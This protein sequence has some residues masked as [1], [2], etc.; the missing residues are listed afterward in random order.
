[1]V[2]LCSRFDKLGRLC[3]QF[4]GVIISWLSYHGF[5][6]PVPSIPQ[7]IPAIFNRIPLQLRSGI[8]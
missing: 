6:K 1:M 3:E 4:A 2:K 8:R 7:M 5:L